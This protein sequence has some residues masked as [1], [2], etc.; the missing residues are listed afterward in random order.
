MNN[1]SYNRD[2]QTRRSDDSM[3]NGIVYNEYIR[4]FEVRVIDELGDQLGIMPTRQALSLARNKGLDLVEITAD[5][6]PAVVRI[7]QLDKWLYN[8]KKAKKEQDKKARENAIV[9]KEIQLRPV[10]DKHDI[11]VKQSHAKEF[12]N[13]NAKVKVVI[14]FKGRELG[15][16][17][18]GHEVMNLFIEG[19]GPCK[20]EKAP[21]LTGKIMTAIIAPNKK[22]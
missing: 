11:Q 15:F 18:K 19:L 16:I 12:L 4:H 20:I 6:K 17:E 22:V 7:V 10:T 21:E 13:D 8:L 9:V 14:K 5:A 1:N 3:Q 2:R